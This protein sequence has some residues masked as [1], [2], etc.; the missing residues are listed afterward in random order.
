[1]NEIV[2]RELPTSELPQIVLI[3]ND[4]FENSVFPGPNAEDYLQ[5]WQNQAI[6]IAAKAG[7]EHLGY[8]IFYA[9]N[10]RDK[11]AYISMIAVR[12]KYQGVHI[13]QRL[14]DEC[15]RISKDCGMFLIRLEVRK[16]NQKALSLY[17]KN[18]FEYES[19]AR[20]ESIYMRK[21]LK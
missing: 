6:F 10:V 12:P 8:A 7:K 15:F 19:E 5:K 9:N 2:I 16:D 17:R 3:C 18:G 4:A 21:T 20:S 13:G 1:M 11:I 14:L